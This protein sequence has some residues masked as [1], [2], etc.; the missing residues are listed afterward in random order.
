MLCD[1]EQREATKRR[2][3]PSILKRELGVNHA[4]IIKMAPFRQ[5]CSAG[6]MLLVR[7][8]VEGWWTVVLLGGGGRWVGGEREKRG[9]SG[10]DGGFGRQVLI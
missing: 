10:T 5:F 3:N 7:Y 8:V 9:L 2:R 6:L 4:E 1:V